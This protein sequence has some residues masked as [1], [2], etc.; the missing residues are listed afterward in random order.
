MGVPKL[1][2]EILSGPLDG[3]VVTL[4]TE[5][6]WSKAGDGPLSFPWDE[7]LGTPQ[8]RLQVEAS[9]WSLVALPNER[10]T[11]HN[12]ERIEDTVPLEKDDLLKAANSWL[13]I[14]QIE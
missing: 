1:T 11:R 6:E 12:M 10:S 5:T 9:R 14:S 3:Q 8:A 13:L 7:Q 4:E 2:L